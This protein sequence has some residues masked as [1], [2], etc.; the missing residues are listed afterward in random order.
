MDTL[1]PKMPFPVGEPEL[2]LQRKSILILEL[3]KVKRRSQLPRRRRAHKLCYT[4]RN[5]SDL[6]TLYRDPPQQQADSATESFW[7]DA[8]NRT[9]VAALPI[10]EPQVFSSHLVQPLTFPEELEHGKVVP[11]PQT[12]KRPGEHLIAYLVWHSGPCKL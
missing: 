11:D 9:L 12:E 1:A 2:M 8:N 5:S 3:C 10:P 7:D 6:Q 4:S